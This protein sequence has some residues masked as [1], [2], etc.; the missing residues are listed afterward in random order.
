MT[1]STATSAGPI[2]G[3]KNYLNNETETYGTFTATEGQILLTRVLDGDRASI[4]QGSSES[5]STTV[6]LTFSLQQKSAIVSRT[7][8]MFAFLNINWAKFTVKSSPDGSAYTLITGLDFSSTANTATDLIVNIPAG[9]AT[10]YIQIAITTTLTADQRKKCGAIFACLGAVQLA[11]G[12]ESYNVKAPPRGNLRRQVMADGTERREYVKYSGASHRFYEASFELQIATQAELNS[13][14]TIER[15]GEPICFFSQP[16]DLTRDVHQVWLDGNFSDTYE[17][18][19]L[20]Q[21][22]R[23]PIKVRDVGRA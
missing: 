6:T 15:D 22:Y 19:I 18:P 10:K 3:S 21:G 12:L 16:G 14:R 5:D 9:I 8:D 4:W 13:L 11:N 20:S 2:F 1:F 7:I 23:I 17:T